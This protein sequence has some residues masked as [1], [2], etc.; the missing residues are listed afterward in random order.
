MQCILYKIYF[1]KVFHM[2]YL[3]CIFIC[4][5][6]C[7]KFYS[8]KKWVLQAQN[9]LNPIWSTIDSGY[10]WTHIIK[11]SCFLATCWSKTYFSTTTI[12]FSFFPNF[13]VACC[14]PFLTWHDA[15]ILRW[16][17]KWFVPNLLPLI[18]IF[19]HQ[20]HFAFCLPTT[21]TWSNSN[22]TLALRFL[23]LFATGTSSFSSTTT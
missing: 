23:Y 22:K 3:I 9:F 10:S 19:L 7:T 11:A 15:Q 1:W 13:K 21:I 12:P 18:R 20:W 6:I 2:Y 16:P 14:R 17:H 4:T 5:P 8:C